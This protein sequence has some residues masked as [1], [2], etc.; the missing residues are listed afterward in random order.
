M[1]YS[2]LF[3]LELFEIYEFISAKP[4]LLGASDWELNKLNGPN[5]LK[6]IVSYSGIVANRYVARAPKRKGIDQAAKAGGMIPAYPIE[7]KKV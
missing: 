1:P 6:E 5:E 3:R 2:V 7:R 4:I